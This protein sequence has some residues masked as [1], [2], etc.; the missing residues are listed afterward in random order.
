MD[1]EPRL[2]DAF[3]AVRGAADV[4]GAI[5]AVR[6][7][8]GLAHCTY[9]LAR[10]VGETYDSPFVRTTYPDA[11]V[12]RYLLR[13][14]IKLDPIVAEGFD[15]RLPFDWREISVTER[16]LP[17]MIDAQAHGLGGQG[18]SVPIT[19]KAA[20]RALFSVN[21]T[22]DAEAWDGFIARCRES[23]VEV[24]GQVHRKAVIELYGEADPVPHLGP[25]ELECLVW[26]ARGKEAPAIATILSISEHTARGYLKSAR[27]KLDCATVSQAVARAI[28][29][30]MIE[31]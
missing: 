30:R 4:D 10:T 27:H 26:S 18:F 15:R 12:S 8:Y 14:Y 29:M 5:R 1:G 16:V 17:M 31:P 22:V 13:D 24:A 28:Q 2:E 23:L 21:H 19:D 3:D 11:W 9:H 6:D 7:L 25:R 20:R